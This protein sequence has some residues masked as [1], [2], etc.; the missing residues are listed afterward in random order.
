MTALEP[1]C[2]VNTCLYPSLGCPYLVQSPTKDTCQIN[3]GC[4]P[5]PFSSLRYAASM[6]HTQDNQTIPNILTTP[7]RAHV[8]HTWERFEL[9]ESRKL[10]S[11]G[12]LQGVLETREVHGNCEA[13]STLEASLKC[14]ARNAP[15][16]STLRP[17]PPPSLPLAGPCGGPPGARCP[18]A[19]PERGYEQ[20][21]RMDAQ[22][23]AGWH[24]LNAGLPP[25]RVRSC[26]ALALV[27]P[28]I[29]G[30][31]RGQGGSGPRAR[32]RVGLRA[33]EKVELAWKSL[34]S[35]TSSTADC[36]PACWEHRRNSGYAPLRDAWSQRHGC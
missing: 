32:V 31:G 9:L 22:P 16:M 18:P 4:M 2:T 24:K 11:Q 33:T 15:R 12:P 19:P 36:Q 34:Q 28:G 5:A 3:Q 14:S 8:Q 13:L 7:W 29:P 10:P 30:D 21:R 35:E 25:S 27:L 17:A 1:S 23:S 26:G 20:G 6:F